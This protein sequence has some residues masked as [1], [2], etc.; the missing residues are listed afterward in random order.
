MQVRVKVKVKVKLSPLCLEGIGVG[1]VL[2][3]VSA[4]DVGGGNALTASRYSLK[5]WLDCVWP[6]QG[7][8]GRVW[9]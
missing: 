9:R 5:W 1:D 4:S 7:R 2:H 3:S 6:I 8:S